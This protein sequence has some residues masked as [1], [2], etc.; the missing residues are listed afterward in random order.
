MSLQNFVSLRCAAKAAGPK[1]A[2]CE[3]LTQWSAAQRKAMDDML[4]FGTPGPDGRPITAA[5]K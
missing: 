4:T 3:Q 1:P 2:I 5:D